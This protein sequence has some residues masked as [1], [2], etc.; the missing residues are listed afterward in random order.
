MILIVGIRLK[1]SVSFSID[2]SY[3]VQDDVDNI[4]FSLQYRGRL[5][6]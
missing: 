4:W 2:T 1:D 3:E 6:S 5:G